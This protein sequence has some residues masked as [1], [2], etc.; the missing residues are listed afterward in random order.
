M[1]ERA[2][3]E[4]RDALTRRA[5]VLGVAIASA[6]RSAVA[7][8]TRGGAFGVGLTAAA[9]VLD[10]EGTRARRSAVVV[11]RA[12][13][14]DAQRLGRVA[15]SPRCA[16]ARKATAASDVVGA[17]Q[18]VREARRAVG[19]AY[20]V[21][22]AGAKVGAPR[23][24]ARRLITIRAIR[25]RA[26][27]VRLAV[28]NAN[29]SYAASADTLVTDARTA[30]ARLQLQSSALAVG[31]AKVSPAACLLRTALRVGAA[32]VPLVKAA[33]TGVRHRTASAVETLRR[34]MARISWC[35]VGR[36]RHVG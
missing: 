16:L 24:A 6:A 7:A 18:V 8:S 1:A 32:V 29:V 2:G 31:V 12:V 28:G 5:G 9:M 30:L 10:A 11:A 34:A 20:A 25:A 15:R 35:A 23:S 26:I 36:R 27:R 19:I 17:A 13:A 33:A 4:D 22:V 3:R 21:L 14:H